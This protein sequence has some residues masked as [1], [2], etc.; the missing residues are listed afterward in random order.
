MWVF[1][2]CLVNCSTLKTGE[3]MKWPGR[4]YFQPLA[5]TPSN[6]YL[7]ANT[8]YIALRY[9]LGTIAVFTKTY[10]IP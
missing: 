9:D 5:G 6:E 1:N 8:L 3:Y 7:T 4:G 10:D 2:A